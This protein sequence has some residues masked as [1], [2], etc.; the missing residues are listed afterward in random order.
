VAA[1]RALTNIEILTGQVTE[2]VFR[3]AGAG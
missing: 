2:E 1:S 3:N